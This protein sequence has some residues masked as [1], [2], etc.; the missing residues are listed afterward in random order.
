MTRTIILSAFL[1]SVAAAQPRPVIRQDAQQARIAQGARSGSLTQLETLRLG[2]QSAAL[3]SQ[4]RRDRVDGGG[5]T[6]AERARIERRQDGL[7]RRI[8]A[9]KTDRQRR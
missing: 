5:L 2:R 3:Q 8:T 4:I 9:Q 7:S 1:L 6:L